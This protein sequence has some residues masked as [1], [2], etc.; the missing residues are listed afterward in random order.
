[1][2]GTADA[3]PELTKELGKP[4]WTVYL[5]RC[6]SKFRKTRCNWSTPAPHAHKSARRL[7][8]ASWMGLVLSNAAVVIEIVRP[9]LRCA[10]WRC[11][12]AAKVEA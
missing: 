2:I 11:H 12:G 3:L 1:M 9:R 10:G 4:S 7:L 6:L 8:R 5:N